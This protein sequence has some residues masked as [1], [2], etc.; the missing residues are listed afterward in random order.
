MSTSCQDPR[1][2]LE[3]EEYS[4]SARTSGSD[5]Q[6]VSRSAPRPN[7]RDRECGL[8]RWAIRGR[9]HRRADP[10]RR[11]SPATESGARVRRRSRLVPR[12]DY[13]HIYIYT[14]HRSAAASHH[15]QQPRLGLLESARGRI[16]LAA[17]L[18]PRH[19]LA[20]VPGAPFRNGP[21]VALA[22]LQACDANFNCVY[23]AS[24]PVTLR[25]SR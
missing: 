14:G 10:Q 13:A 23:V 19:P 22:S 1:N 18:R 12:F 3:M 17:R 21:A 4:T 15:A 8:V 11:P 2:S 6:L 20:S 24:E 7:I 25:I 9:S 16:G 5:L